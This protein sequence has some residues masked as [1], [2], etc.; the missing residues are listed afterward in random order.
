MANTMKGRT[1]RCA[2]CLTPSAVPLAAFRG[3]CYETGACDRGDAAGECCRRT[4][5]ATAASKVGAGHG[6]AA[7]G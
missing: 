7:H 3:Y 4:A 6:A 5:Y 1:D 2:L